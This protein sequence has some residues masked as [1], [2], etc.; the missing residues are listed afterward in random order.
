MKY[1]VI[2]TIIFISSF[3]ILIYF[4]R[5]TLKSRFIETLDLIENFNQKTSVHFNY[6][7]SNSTRIVAWKNTIKIIQNN[8]WFGAGT[9]DF[10]DELN[11]YYISEN[12]YSLAEKN[13]NA[14][15]QFIQDF[16]KLGI[17]HLLLLIS[18][19]IFLFIQTSSSNYK[20]FFFITFI[21]FLFESMLETQSGTIFF[22]FTTTLTILTN[23]TS[24]PSNKTNTLQN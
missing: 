22:S 16:A 15:N 5:H 4:T 7:E 8:F 10:K 2:I 18:I 20:I 1:Q 24:A 3:S 17:I 6:L 11:K 12:Y 19:F 21:N 13:I 9:G 23:F 14:H